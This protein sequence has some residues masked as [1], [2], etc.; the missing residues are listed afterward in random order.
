[1]ISD[2]EIIFLMSSLGLFLSGI[3]II[4]IWFYMVFLECQKLSDVWGDH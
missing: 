3:F 1:M 2:S 4:G